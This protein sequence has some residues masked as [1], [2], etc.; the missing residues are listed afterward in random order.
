[1][2][3]ALDGRRDHVVQ[4]A[5]LDPNTAASL[6]IEQIEAL[7]DDLIEAHGAALPE[8]IGAGAAAGV[9]S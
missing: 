6:P 9:R 1:M 7:V 4:A 2:R 8:G 5:M 3:A